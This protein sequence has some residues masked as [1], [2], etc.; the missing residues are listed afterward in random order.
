MALS[1]FGA[2]SCMR[3]NGCWSMFEGSI[4]SM[5]TAPI[6]L[7][8]FVLYFL[9]SVAFG[10]RMMR[11]EFGN[12]VAW[13][14]LDTFL[15]AGKKIG[16]GS[17]FCFDVDEV[18]SFGMVVALKPNVHAAVLYELSKVIDDFDYRCCY[19]AQGQTRP[20]RNAAIQFSGNHC[21]TGTVPTRLKPL[22]DQHI[23]PQHPTDLAQEDWS[24]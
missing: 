17:V 12:G 9:A 5:Q 22:S 16:Q 24:P 11:A 2:L 1:T 13:Q 8:I 3:K 6:S 14:E 7:E 20:M 15:A 23:N 4:M 21:I 18:K 19:K 10:L